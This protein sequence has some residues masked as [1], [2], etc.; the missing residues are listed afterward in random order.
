MF[1][2]AVEEKLYF[3]SRQAPHSIKQSKKYESTLEIMKKYQ[4]TVGIQ[5]GYMDCSKKLVR[6]AVGKAEL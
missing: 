5:G 1:S 4:I 6:H 3:L 2:F